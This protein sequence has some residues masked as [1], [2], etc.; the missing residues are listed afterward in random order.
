MPKYF[1]AFLWIVALAAAAVGYLGIF[2]EVFGKPSPPDTTALLLTAA[3]I[4]ATVGQA[5]LA[6]TGRFDFGVGGVFLAAHYLCAAPN[7]LWATVA[8]LFVLALAAAT[9]NTLGHCALRLPNLLVTAFVGLAAAV[10][11]L[12]AGAVVQG[13]AVGDFLPAALAKNSL[14]DL[15]EALNFRFIILLA[16]LLLTYFFLRSSPAGWQ[17]RALGDDAKKARAFVPRGRL[18]V[19]YFFSAL[20][21]AAAAVIGDGAEPLRQLS[22]LLTDSLAENLATVALAPPLPAML[23]NIFLAVAL[24]APV[25]CA[26]VGAAGQINIRRFLL[27]ALAVALLAAVVNW[28]L[29]GCFFSAALLIAGVAG[30]LQ[31]RRYA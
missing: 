7:P 9:V 19:A 3:L 17:L 12:F 2:P 5:P 13:V 22:A 18:W 16:M 10:L 29:F 25:W 30:R 14:A 6:T 20:G 27:N 1:T 26:A 15:R 11:A 31:K 4:A 21:G 28:Q 8:A 23:G 24:T